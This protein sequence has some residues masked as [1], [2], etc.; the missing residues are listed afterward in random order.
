[1]HF[2]RQEWRFR[3]Q[4]RSYR[5]SASFCR[6]ELVR[7]EGGAVDAFPASGMALSR[8]SSLLQVI[9]ELL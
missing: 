8:T 9:R 7:D 1:M 4:V 6:S 3:E 5:L 2:L